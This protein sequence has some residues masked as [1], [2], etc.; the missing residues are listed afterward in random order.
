[1]HWT[2][3]VWWVEQSMCPEA[4]ETHRSGPHCHWTSVALSRCWPDGWQSHCWAAVWCEG[5]IHVW[6]V[7]QLWWSRAETKT[8][9]HLQWPNPRSQS[10]GDCWN[11]SEVFWMRFC[12]WFI[13]NFQQIL[14]N[15]SLKPFPE[16]CGPL[17][18]V[19]VIANSMTSQDS[20]LGGQQVQG[21]PS[22]WFEGLGGVH[23]NP[24]RCSWCFE[25][26]GGWEDNPTSNINN[27]GSWIHSKSIPYC[28]PTGFWW[29]YC[30]C[31]WV[32]FDLPHPYYWWLLCQQNVL[33]METLKKHFQ[34]L[35]FGCTTPPQNLKVSLFSRYV[36]LSTKSKTVEFWWLHLFALQLQIQNLRMVCSAVMSDSKLEVGVAQGNNST[37]HS[38]WI[39]NTGS[40][41]ETV[42]VRELFGFNT[43]SF[44]ELPPGYWVSEIK[45]WTCT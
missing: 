16:D 9:C 30:A 33:R 10:L 26:C 5:S 1:M 4:A 11:N 35:F 34:H 36:C 45:T 43:G 29:R 14:V 17:T 8:S 44:T 37:D 22:E 40:A 15:V 6:V 32:E 38:L 21:Q 7:G 18:W 25:R 27:S 24:Y 42:S 28:G 12:F 20:R 41:N 13:S 2:T 19:I 31:I 3:E 23:L 39:C